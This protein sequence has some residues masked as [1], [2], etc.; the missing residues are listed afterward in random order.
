MT[1]RRPTARPARIG[2]DAHLLSFAGSYRQ[3]GVSRYIAELLRALAGDADAAGDHDYLAFVGP[4]PVP[5]GFLPASTT[6]RLRFV[7]SRLPTARPLE[8]IAW[9]QALG[10]VAAL[11][12]RLDLIHGPVNAL[13]LAAPGRGVVTIHD[14]A[15]LAHPRALGAARRRYLTL[16]TA[17]SARRAARIIAVSAF[18]RD[19]V[20]RRLRV[21]ARKVAVVHNAVDPAFAPLP[22]AEIARFRA[23]QR[24][25]ERVILC[26]GTLEPRKNL[27][28]LLDAF[29]RLAPRTDAELVVVG[30]QGW[31]YDAAL[32]RV[33]T[34]GLT[35]SVRFAG[36]VPDA[37]LPR[38]YNAATLF[39]YPSLY[40][41]FGLPPLEA[42]ACGV[43][44]VTGAGTAM[45]E[46]VG[47]AALLTDP[48]DPA[49]LAAALARLLDDPALRAT[50][51]E[52]GPRQ[53]APF[54][55][56]RTA[57]ATRAVYD[58]VLTHRPR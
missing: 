57:A 34:L 33:A 35:G 15:F 28:G 3:A 2:I 48:R 53:A 27:V 38:W 50:L 26:V 7:H 16:L 58:E 17:L 49:A 25:P 24:L 32:A 6:G 11:R 19:E 41:G 18:T 45:A 10:P 40:E 21:P 43:P 56:A 23:E 46:I 13:P 8:R 20:V 22:A 30:G 9:E 39:V 51:R 29:A 1:A 54:T 4:E 14:L 5:P 37:D 44:T 55:W 31:L 42:L 36:F 47:D 52:R 12:A